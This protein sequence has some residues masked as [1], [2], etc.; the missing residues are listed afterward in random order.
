[1]PRRGLREKLTGNRGVVK[2]GG[3]ED[4]GG[5][6][7]LIFS[8]APARGT[9]LMPARPGHERDSSRVRRARLSD[10]QARAVL[11]GLA[12]TER[13]AAAAAVA[14]EAAAAAPALARQGD[15]QGA[16]TGAGRRAQA[17]GPR[18][19]TRPCRPRAPR[20]LVA[21]PSCRTPCAPR[22]T[23]TARAWA[24]RARRGCSPR[25]G[26]GCWQ[27]LSG[28]RRRRR[29]CCRRWGGRQ[30]RGEWRGAAA[31]RGR[32]ARGAF[33]FPLTR[34]CLGAARK[35][36]RAAGGRGRRGRKTRAAAAAGGGR[37]NPPNRVVRAGPGCESCGGLLHHFG[38]YRRPVRGSR[39]VGA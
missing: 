26:R 4:G 29:R 25:R 16:A 36:R 24:G 35:K 9:R 22:P 18:R 19:A 20:A 27:K 3:G 38:L 23:P 28:G 21:G 31:P 30:R 39:G 2:G 6:L 15:G 11:V 10:A 8:P 34:G 37:S 32:G 13:A 12:R 5:A 14:A 1:M 17:T 7:C 33:P